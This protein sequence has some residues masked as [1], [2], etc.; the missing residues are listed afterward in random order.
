MKVLIIGGTGNISTA[1]SRMLLDRGDDLFLY[2]RGSRP[3]AGAVQVT[4]DRSR[5]GEFEEQM[6]GL[7]VREKYFDVVYDMVGYHP[8]DA[9]SLVR[10]FGGK[11]GQLIFCSTVDVYTKPAPR[12]PVVEGFERNPNPAFEYAYHKALM[13]NL[14]IDAER[15]GAFSVTLLRPAATYNDASAPISQLGSGLAL[16]RRIRDGRPVIVLG[17]GHSFW[18]SSHR[19][20]V[21]VS[22]VAAAGNPKAMGKAYHLTGDEWITWREYYQTAAR[23]M[24]AP[25]I[26]FVPIPAD[27]LARMT[28]GA[29]NWCS[30]N[31]KFNNIFDNTASKTDLAYRY[32]ISWEE[33]VRRMVAYHDQQGSIDSADQDPL[34]DRVIE[35]YKDH[36]DL[37]A[38]SLL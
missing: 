37:I 19:D 9:R 26:Q 8:E 20:D 17:D 23:V 13:E 28:H 36:I 10:A 6:A 16:L 22:F 29:A 1:I 25:P 21:A 2:N 35:A 5:H 31:F 15:Q 11:I 30:W 24:Q 34:Y 12:Y 7:L 38:K 4:G 27:D 14:F 33:G 3:L 18:T 32:T